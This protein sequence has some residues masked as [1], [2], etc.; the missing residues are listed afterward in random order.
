SRTSPHNVVFLE[1][2][3]AAL[4]GDPLF[5]DGWY[6][7]QP[8]QGLRAAARVYAGWGFSQAFYWH[9]TYKQLGFHSLDDFLVGFWEGF[10]LDDRDVNDL[11]CMADTWKHTDVGRT[12]GFDGDIAAALATIRA[13]ALIMPAEKDL[14]FPPEDEQWAAQYI[15]DAEVRIIPGVWGHF[16][17]SG[18]N[19]ED[20]RFIDNAVSELLARD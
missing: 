19:P 14:Y 13:K 16:S 1:S 12:P 3:K 17:G 5:R 18:D 9:E 2:V 6:E 20:V 4:R 11:L 8:T 15:P 10:F 7:Q